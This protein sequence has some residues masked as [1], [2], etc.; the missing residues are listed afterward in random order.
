MLKLCMSLICEL[1]E[2]CTDD[3]GAG[4]LVCLHRALSVRGSF[5]IEIRWAQPG[6]LSCRFTAAKWRGLPRDL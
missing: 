6:C 2:E 4:K 3:A 1:G 5:P